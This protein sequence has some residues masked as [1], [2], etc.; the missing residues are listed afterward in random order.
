M[1]QNFQTSFIPKKPIIEERVSAS[2]PV[3]IFM[4][5]SLIILFAILLGTG[6]LY[7][8]KTTVVKNNADMENS[9]TL[10][11]NSFEPSKLTELQVLD[12]RLNAATQILSS[13][14]A[15][16]PIFT[17]L[18]KI[19]MNSV[20][21]TTFTYTLGADAN[22]NIDVKMSGIATDYRSVALQSDLFAQ[23]KNFLNPVFSNLTVD[24]NGNILFDLEFS[25]VPSFVNY[26]QMLQAQ[27]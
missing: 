2:Q 19:T 11:Q 22:S 8:Y 14:I 21:F 12:K 15:V 4:I 6:G 24:N 23:D 18:G 9:L 27:S 20:R 13:H 7:F 26:K 25:V 3:N 10:A 5:A 17:E 16:T 1:D